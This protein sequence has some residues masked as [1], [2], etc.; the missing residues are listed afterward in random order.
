MIQDILYFVKS[1]DESYIN[2]FLVIV[3]MIQDASNVDNYTLRRH[4][5]Q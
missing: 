5:R 4:F 3:L 2:L 1:Y